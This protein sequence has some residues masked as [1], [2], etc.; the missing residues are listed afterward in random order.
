MPGFYKLGFYILNINNDIVS[1]LILGVT[2]GDTV[3]LLDETKTQCKIRLFGN[4]IKQQ[5]SNLCF[6]QQTSVEVT[7]KDRYG[8]L[9][10]AVTRDDINA[11]G[12]AHFRH[13]MGIP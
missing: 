8:R 3:T 5:L 10:G 11:R 6:R 7:D 12:Y 2:D 1:S 9:M 4:P 13:N